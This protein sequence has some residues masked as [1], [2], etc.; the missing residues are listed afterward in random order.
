MR[1]KINKAAEPQWGSWDYAIAS[2]EDLFSYE[3]WGRTVDWDI[4]LKQ[5]EKIQ[6][7][8]QMIDIDLYPSQPFFDALDLMETH[9]LVLDDMVYYLTGVRIDGN[10]P[11]SEET[12]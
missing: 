7:A 5:V 12:Q 8:S 11:L 1:T 2:R 6:H 3:H 4:I 9:L 10:K